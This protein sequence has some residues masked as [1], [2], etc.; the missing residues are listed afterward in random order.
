MPVR[1]DAAS[2]LA[3]LFCSAAVM[4]SAAGCSPQGDPPGPSASPAVESSAGP[5]PASPTSSADQGSPSSS[6]QAPDSSPYPA[7]SMTITSLEE[8][9]ERLSLPA[10]PTVAVL[11][12]ADAFALHLPTCPSSRFDIDVTAEGDWI[13]RPSTIQAGDGCAPAPPEVVQFRE[14]TRSLFDGEME[15]VRKEGEIVLSGREITMV[16]TADPS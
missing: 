14:A 7:T 11:E 12:S 1:Q 16:L 5:S 8:A 9:G 2:A 4:A 6:T 15:V 13:G 10:R 3:A